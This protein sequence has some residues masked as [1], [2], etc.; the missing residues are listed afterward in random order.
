MTETLDHVDALAKALDQTHT[1]ISRIDAEQHG[2]TTPC[3]SWD[4]AA[5]VGHVLTDLEQFTAGARGEEVDW[6]TGPATVDPDLWA[7]EF[8][9]RA[10]VLVAAW[11]RAEPSGAID[12]QIS[13]LALHAWDLEK[14][15]GQET[16]LDP[17]LAE[18]GL[19]WMQGMLKDEYRGSEADGKSFGPEVRV[20]KDA[21]AYA[22]LA[23][24][25]GRTPC[26]EG[27]VHIRPHSWSTDAGRIGTSPEPGYGPTS[28]NHSSSA[29]A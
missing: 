11:R 4:V 8:A 26:P 19:A 16:A 28:P 13:E 18:V 27:R 6:T 10:S 29:G 1:V 15:T 14:A 20:D 22:R 2:D 12:M 23:A 9:A 25:S 21:G 3:A 5:I 24:F 7:D 17:L